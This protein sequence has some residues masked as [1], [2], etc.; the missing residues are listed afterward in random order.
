MTCHAIHRGGRRH[1]RVR[2]LATT[3]LSTIL[4]SGAAWAEDIPEVVIS[5]PRLSIPAEAK[6]SAA[7]DTARLLSGT[8]GLNLITNGGV[9]SLPDIH[10]LADDRLKILVDGMELTSA[11]SNHMNPALSYM[12]SSKVERVEVWSGITPVSA[13]GDN[14]GGVISVKAAPPVFA[15]PGEGYA[16]GGRASAFFKSVNTGIG[17]SLAVH[18]ADDTYSL[19]YD[20]SWVRGLNYSAGGDGRTVHSTRYESRNHE[21]SLGVK[22]NAGLLVLKAG[23][24]DIPFQGFANQRMDMTGNKGYH[25]NGRYEGEFGWGK[26]E[27]RAYWQQV[28]HAMDQAANEKGGKMPMRTDA[29]DVGYAVKGDINLS[30]AS[31][32]RIGHE[33]HRFM[34]EDWWPP[35]AGSASMSPLT[36]QSIY[37]GTRDVVSAFAEWEEKWSPQWTTLLGLRSDTVLMDTGAVHGYGTAQEGIDATAFNGRNHAKIDANFDLTALVRYEP[38]GT[39]TN[40]LG[41]A[42]KSRSP[43]LYERYSWSTSNMDSRMINWTG[44]A[45]GYLGNLDLKPEVAHTVSTSVALHDAGRKDWG[46]KATPYA[47][48]IVDYIGVDKVRNNVS[49]GANY[50]LLKFA[51]HD[52]MMYGIDFSGSAVF[53]R[54]TGWGD[55]KLTGRLGW[56]HGEMVNTGKAMYHVMPINGKAAIEQSLGGW[57]SAIEAELV[58]TKAGVDTLRQEPKTPGYALLN[59]RGGYEWEAV[60]VSLGVDNLFDRRYYHPLGGV[61]Y[62][63]MRRTGRGTNTQAGPLAAPGRSLNAG[64]TVK[65]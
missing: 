55:F 45:N 24:Q 17:G 23:Q 4:M 61:D 16:V 28:K 58:G 3:F 2:L 13:G 1:G 5:A 40:E 51:N 6:A 50:P 29:T 31:T 37:G 11:C 54:D 44:D 7:G 52:A 62:T 49:G 21:L 57:T 47:T 20:G 14:I 53:A 34:L 8:P 41:Y 39:N 36:F 22:G 9:S 48:Y 60:Q 46:I 15:A 33:F 63:E 38:D 64:V 30:Q 19:G 12:D 65:F 25:G 43:N 56:L 32:L 18:G 10:G 59:L 35:V 26:L 42:R 27:A